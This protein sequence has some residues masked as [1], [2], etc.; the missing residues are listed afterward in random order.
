MFSV[1][2]GVF[3]GEIGVGSFVYYSFMSL[4]LLLRRPT[5]NSLYDLY[6]KKRDV[7]RSWEVGDGSWEGKGK[8]GQFGVWRC[9]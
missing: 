7:L 5:Y 2:F 3:S 9:E 4:N 6:V 8:S 1:E